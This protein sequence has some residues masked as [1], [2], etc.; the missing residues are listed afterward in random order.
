METRQSAATKHPPKQETGQLAQTRPPRNGNL[1]HTP[2]G[3]KGLGEL[4]CKGPPAVLNGSTPQPSIQKSEGRSQ[5]RPPLH[6]ECGRETTTH[7][8]AGFVC[9]WPAAGGGLMGYVFVVFVGSIPHGLGFER[10]AQGHR[11]HVGDPTPTKRRTHT[12][13][14]FV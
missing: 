12:N 11:G 2:T 8:E 9:L 14:V 7:G 10:T 1:A 13:C 5:P 6:A 3:K 4:P